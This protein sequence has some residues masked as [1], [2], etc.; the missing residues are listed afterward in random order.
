MDIA[1][2]LRERKLKQEEERRVAVMAKDVRLNTRDAQRSTRL[3]WRPKSWW[4]NFEEF[5]GKLAYNYFNWRQ[6]L[7]FP[8]S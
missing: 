4:A 7:Y 8:C 6:V 1:A 5:K 3:Q 2:E